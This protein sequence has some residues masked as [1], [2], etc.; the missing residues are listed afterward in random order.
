MLAG[1]AGDDFIYAGAGND[2]VNGQDGSDFV[3]G[4]AGNDLLYGGTGNDGLSNAAGNDT[5]DGGSGIDTMSGGAGADTYYVDN[6]N[7]VIREVGADIDRVASSASYTLSANVENLT[8]T[9]AARINAVGNALNNVI[10]GNLP[11]TS[12]MAE[13]ATTISPPAAGMTA[14]MAA[15]ATTPSCSIR[16]RGQATWIA[17]WISTSLTTPS[18]LKTES[19]LR[20]GLLASA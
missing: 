1:G 16:R 2:R 13:T 4:E 15:G 20:W 18:G 3:Y 6:A 7:D 17:S 10:S 19:S 11:R 14:S 9:G 5:M 8:L 12:S